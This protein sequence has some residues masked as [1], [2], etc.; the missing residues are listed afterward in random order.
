MLT[1]LLL[2]GHITV[3][4][5]AITVAYGSG[6]MARLAYMTGQ[7]AAV[8]GV[9]MAAARLG[10]FIPILFIL[11]GLLGL[12]TAVSVGANLL[13]PWLVIAYSLWTI[14]MLIGILENR[15]WGMK[16]GAILARTPDGPL[17]PELSAMFTDRR[18][19]IG[20]VVDYALVL[21]L[22][23]DMVVKPFS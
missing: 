12:F 5:V 15:P 13:A 10:P 20:T 2:F 3:M 4:F 6:L 16:L 17:T 7:V 8:R 19:V 11:G 9:G 1:P 22:I 23:Y 21:L 14:A 18:V